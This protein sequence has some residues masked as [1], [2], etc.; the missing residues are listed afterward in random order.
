MRNP[1]KI[2]IVPEL[3]MRDGRI[4]RSLHD[5]IALLREHELRPGVD[6][7]DEVLHRLERARTEQECRQAI[8]AFI[9][10]A[11]E[12]DLLLEPPEATRLEA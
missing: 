11:R 5:A 1:A 9:A 6:A 3:T 4:I 2:L 7:R 8:D 12:L 10:W